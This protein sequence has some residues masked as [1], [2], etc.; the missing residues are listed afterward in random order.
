[1]R[2]LE[3][4]MVTA[5]IRRRK[6]NKMAKSK[7]TSRFN[8]NE[9]FAVTRMLKSSPQKLNLVAQLIRG[10]SVEQAINILNFSSKRVSLDVKKTLMSAV[11]NAENNNGMDVDRLIVTEAWVGKNLVL[12]RGRPRGRGRFGRILKPFSQI[13]VK[14]SEIQEAE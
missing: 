12:K 14:L 9:A 13:S 1:M 6:E 3:L 11:A 7:K 10:K 8:S 5:L 4:T 2:Q